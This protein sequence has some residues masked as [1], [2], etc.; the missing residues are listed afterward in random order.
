MFPQNWII[1]YF[2]SSSV[3]R[4]IY[5][6]QLKVKEYGELAERHTEFLSQLVYEFIICFI[7]FLIRKIIGKWKGIARNLDGDK[8]NPWKVAC[9]KTVN[10]GIQGIKI[11]TSSTV[12]NAWARIPLEDRTIMV[13]E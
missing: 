10:A 11:D 1:E 4:V 8:R 3:S 2:E 13:C 9:I 6:I 5:P 7:E 12:I